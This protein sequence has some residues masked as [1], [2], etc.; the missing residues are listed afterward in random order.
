[1]Y[2]CANISC[3]TNEPFSEILCNSLS[4]MMLQAELRLPKNVYAEVLMLNTSECDCIW[5]ECI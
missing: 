1:M 3:N 5:R 4:S 2:V